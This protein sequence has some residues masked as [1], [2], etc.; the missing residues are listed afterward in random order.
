MHPPYWRR[1][2]V[3]G[4]RGLYGFSY[5][6]GKCGSLVGNGCRSEGEV[7]VT[8]RGDP[9]TISGERSAGICFALR[10]CR[11][12]EWVASVRVLT[13]LISKGCEIVGSR[14]GSGW[15]A[16][17]GPCI[18]RIPPQTLSRNSPPQRHAA[19]ISLTWVVQFIRTTMF[20]RYIV[21]ARYYNMSLVVH[22]I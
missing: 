13:V 1:G 15:V 2:L 9:Q 17:E 3:S 11:I 6:R 7:E 21:R 18:C 16:K 10:C 20:K 4:G 8:A 22:H 14:G 19:G 5:M 12:L